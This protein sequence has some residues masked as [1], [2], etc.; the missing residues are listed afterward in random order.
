MSGN[1][2]VAKIMRRV[3]DYVK[4]GRI[5]SGEMFDLSGLL[6]NCHENNSSWRIDSEVFVSSNRRW[7]GPF[8]N[9]FKKV[10]RKVL[11][12]YLYPFACQ[13]NR[14]NGSVTRSVN[15]IYRILDSINGV[16]G[17]YAKEVEY[18]RRDIEWFK[19]R[20]Q[21]I[22]ESVRVIEEQLEKFELRTEESSEVLKKTRETLDNFRYEEKILTDRI[23]RLERK[24]LEIYEIGRVRKDDKKVSDASVYSTVKE[25]S[26]IDYF[27]FEQKFRGSENEVKENQRVYLKYFSPGDKVLDIGC[28]RG[29]FL[30]LLKEKG[31][32]AK[33]VDFDEDFVE[34][35]RDKG[36]DVEKADALMY[37]REI[38]DNS[39]DGIFMSH[40]VEHLKFEDMYTLL[41]LSYKK[42]KEDSL[43]IIETPNPQTL[44]IFTNA[45][46]VDPTHIKPVHP[47]T[48]EFLLDNIGFRGIEITHYEYSRVKYNIPLLVGEKIH[49][50]A[51]FNDGI[52][53]LNDVLF[54]Y[55]DYTVIAR[56]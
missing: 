56:K 17:D 46:Y 21:G 5:D 12:W 43:L 3:R 19:A 34:Y 32:E 51:D 49:N 35:C 48:L 40:L 53:V 41:E 27:L 39:L 23:R 31:V 29:E 25:G 36:L 2:D 52:N 30:E 47:K 8:I 15:E 42:L 4:Y 37:L 20:L 38:E 33:G 13:V 54:G 10:V 6:V 18:F 11:R 9:F 45:F 14:F 24:L 55:Q 44:A 16:L 50:L 22:D 1:Y 26:T 28:G 7:I